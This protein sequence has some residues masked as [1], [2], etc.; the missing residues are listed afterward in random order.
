MLQAAAIRN[1]WRRQLRRLK[2]QAFRHI[3]QIELS[4]YNCDGSWLVEFHPPD[5]HSIERSRHVSRPGQEE[6]GSTIEGLDSDHPSSPQSGVEILDDEEHVG[7]PCGAPTSAEDFQ[8]ST[9]SREH[10]DPQAA[11]VG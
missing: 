3:A 10:C 2:T 6:G 9:H 4:D 11:K 8:G 7:L 5:S 1:E